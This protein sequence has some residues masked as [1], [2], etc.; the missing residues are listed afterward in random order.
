MTLWKAGL[1]MS[2]AKVTLKIAMEFLYFAEWYAKLTNLQRA[3]Q[4]SVLAPIQ[5]AALHT[6]EHSKK[7]VIGSLHKF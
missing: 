5:I 3:K 6:K 7:T 4:T 1:S 2:Y